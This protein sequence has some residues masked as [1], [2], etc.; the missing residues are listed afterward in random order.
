MDTAVIRTRLERLREL[1]ERH[2]NSDWG[3]SDVQEFLDQDPGAADLHCPRFAGLVKESGEGKLVVAET[4]AGLADEMAVRVANE[5]PMSAIE[6]IDLDTQ[7]H[8]EAEVTVHFT[9]ATRNL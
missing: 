7:E 2:V 4:I 1:T 5:I 9:A 3:R 8:R 6:M